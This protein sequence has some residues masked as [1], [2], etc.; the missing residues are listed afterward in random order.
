LSNRLV[1]PDHRDRAKIDFRLSSSRT[2]ARLLQV[3]V[4]GAA[5]MGGLDGLL[6]LLRA[7]GCKIGQL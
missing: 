5:N 6:S 3:V 7:R 2:W 4:M 1:R